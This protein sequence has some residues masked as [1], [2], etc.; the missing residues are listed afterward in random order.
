MSLRDFLKLVAETPDV[1]D[2][3][4]LDDFLAVAAYRLAKRRWHAQKAKAS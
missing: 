1:P 4:L 3:I 2:T